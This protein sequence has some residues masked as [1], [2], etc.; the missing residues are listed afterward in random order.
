LETARCQPTFPSA[1]EQTPTGDID[2]GWLKFTS[3]ET[4]TITDS[5]VRAQP[6][7]DTAG[8]YIWAGVLP[9]EFE[10]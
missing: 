9:E 10:R 5:G 3:F 8:W 6:D 1:C 4:D 2:T 7:G